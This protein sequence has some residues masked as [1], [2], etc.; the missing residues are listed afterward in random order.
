L[1]AWYYATEIWISIY[2]TALF[3]FYEPRSVPWERILAA[4]AVCQIECD[5]IMEAALVV[6]PGS[7]ENYDG[8]CRRFLEIMCILFSLSSPYIKKFSLAVS[9]K[10]RSNYRLNEWE[11]STCVCDTKTI[12]LNNNNNYTKQRINV[13]NDYSW[14]NK[15]LKLSNV[16]ITI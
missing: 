15:N 8:E 9:E 6:L 12:I 11:I 10:T 2:I 16:V 1:Y 14:N 7:F 13:M 5:V 3:S 4:K